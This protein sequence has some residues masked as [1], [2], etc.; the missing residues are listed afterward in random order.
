MLG[1]RAP[2]PA[3]SAKRTRFF[4]KSSNRVGFERAVHAV[5]SRAPTLPV[6]TGPTHSEFHT[7]ALPKELNASDDKKVL[8]KENN[9]DHF[10]AAWRI[11]SL[12]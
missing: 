2:S 6:T 1:S 10:L 5:R 3:L 8:P 4:S 7:D 11:R 9:Y 12:A